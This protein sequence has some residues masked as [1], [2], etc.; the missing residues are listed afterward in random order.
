MEGLNMVFAVFGVLML[1]ALF[2]C[3]VSYIIKAVTI[4]VLAKRTGT[5]RTWFAFI[6]FLQNMKVYNLAGFSEKTF[7]AVWLASLVLGMIPV[8]EILFVG[9]ILYTAAT[10]YVKVRTAQNFGGGIWLILL[11]VLFEPFVLIYLAIANKPFNLTPEWAPLANFLHELN[12]DTDFGVHQ[13]ETP[14][15]KSEP[16]DVEI[17]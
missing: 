9:T 16:I 11:N 7:L 3:I 13:K 14:K 10:I 6:P 4:Y 12:I 2:W 15:A 1:F 17:E 8:K 5:P